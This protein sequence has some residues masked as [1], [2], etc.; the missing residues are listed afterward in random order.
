MD[1]LAELL[2]EAELL[3]TGRDALGDKWAGTPEPFSS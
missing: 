3:E 2:S 1:G